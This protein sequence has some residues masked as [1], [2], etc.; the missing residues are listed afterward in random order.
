VLAK[1]KQKSVFRYQPIAI[2][3]PP[4][5]D[6]PLPERYAVADLT[7]DP[8]LP[9][10]ESNAR[11]IAAQLAELGAEQPVVL[12]REPMSDLVPS[13]AINLANGGGAERDVA[14]A[15]INSAQRFVGTLDGLAVLAPFLGVDATAVYDRGVRP[16]AQ[17]LE[18]ASRVLAGGEFGDF[19][20]VAAGQGEAPAEE[21]YGSWSAAR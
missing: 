2:R 3:E 18:L 20:V 4:R 9:K 8:S 10:S 6:R 1:P 5:L 21:R 11:F 14:T 12:L 19:H 15:V 17:E 16:E 7:F 13:E